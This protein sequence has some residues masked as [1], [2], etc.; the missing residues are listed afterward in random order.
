MEETY[1]VEKVLAHSLIEGK[2]H[3]LVKWKNY[4]HDDNSWEPTSNLQAVLWMVDAFHKEIKA[5][6]GIGKS[7]HMSR[8]VF[9]TLGIRFK[10]EV[11]G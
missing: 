2:D 5:K 11:D 10:Q 7:H 9:L 4:P 6:Q 3:Y 1:E 8:L